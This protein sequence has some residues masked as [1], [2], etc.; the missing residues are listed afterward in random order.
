MIELLYAATNRTLP[1]RHQ[2]AVGLRELQI[3]Q[4]IK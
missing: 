2:N 1:N 4:A 3:A